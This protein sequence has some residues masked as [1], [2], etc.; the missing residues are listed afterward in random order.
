MV[1]QWEEGGLGKVGFG[2][3]GKQDGREI[4]NTYLGSLV[5]RPVETTTTTWGRINEVTAAY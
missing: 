5:R 2:G 4:S 1:L 3:H